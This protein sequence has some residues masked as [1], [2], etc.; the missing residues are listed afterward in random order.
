[1]RETVLAHSVVLHQVFTLD[2]IN[3]RLSKV[4]MA[5]YAV[6]FTVWFGRLAMNGEL[7]LSLKEVARIVPVDIYKASFFILSDGNFEV[8]SR[9][10][11]QFRVTLC[12]IDSRAELG[13]AFLASN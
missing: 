6:D 2:S 5:K 7:L 12:V 9:K 1:M 3:Y 11:F 10:V 4:I 13:C 8:L